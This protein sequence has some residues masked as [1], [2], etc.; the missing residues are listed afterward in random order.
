MWV[1]P[2]K[3]ARGGGAGLRD[4]DEEVRDDDR[5]RAELERGENLLAAAGGRARGR[6][7]R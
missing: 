3:S 2:M 5:G 4:D 1:S 7:A 6:G